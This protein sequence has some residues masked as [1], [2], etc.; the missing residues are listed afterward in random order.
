MGETWP[1]LYA[2]VGV[3]SG[4]A[5]GSANDVLSAFAAMR[6]QAAFEPRRDATRDGPRTIVFHGDADATV[7]P[8]NA[9]R[10]VAS[11]GH[12]VT[13][14]TEHPGVDGKRGYARLVSGGEA[15]GALE[16]WIVEGAAHA[17]SGGDARGSYTD[18]R[19]PDAS[20][21]MV[22]FFLEGSG[23]TAAA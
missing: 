10:I 13:V 11:L 16:C 14:R 23:G 21:A 5:H 18:P 1:E 6:G 9:E 7:H 20:A 3:H 4:L 19:G 15:A 12:D 22:R 8:S 2:G 17:W